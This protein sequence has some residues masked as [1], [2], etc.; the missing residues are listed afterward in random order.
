M[1]IFS[2]KQQLSSRRNLFLTPQP[3]FKDGSVA[4]VSSARHT[5]YTCCDFGLRLLSPFMP[6]ITEEVCPS[7]DDF[8]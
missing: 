4:A 5:L 7:A 8:R 6:F 3:V 2:A 1:F